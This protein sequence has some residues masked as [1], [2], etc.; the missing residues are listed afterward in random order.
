MP[1]SM[2]P[3]YVT[4]LFQGFEYS[5]SDVLAALA[6][7]NQ[8]LL[9]IIDLARETFSQNHQSVDACVLPTG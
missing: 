2:I 4:S 3:T 6:L 1:A 5:A 7:L 9:T 8:L